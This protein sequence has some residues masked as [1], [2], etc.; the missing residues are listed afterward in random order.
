MLFMN[1]REI[2]EMR[3]WIE[4]TTLNLILELYVAYKDYFWMMELTESL[5]ENLCIELH[6]NTEV[7]FDKK[8]INFSNPLKN[9]TY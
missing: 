3:G 2:S 5:I 6:N 4:I 1:F 8:K 9:D 7:E